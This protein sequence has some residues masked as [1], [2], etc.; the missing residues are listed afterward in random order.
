MRVLYLC[1]QQTGVATGGEIDAYNDDS[2]DS[3]TC[4]GLFCSVMGKS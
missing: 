4:R 1:S 3:D 2:I